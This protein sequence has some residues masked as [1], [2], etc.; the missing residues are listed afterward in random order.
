[1]IRK[2]HV[3]YK[4]GE[5]PKVTGHWIEAETE[6]DIKRIVLKY[7]IGNPMGQREIEG[8]FIKDQDFISFYAG[9][10]HILSFKNVCVWSERDRCCL[11]GTPIKVRYEELTRDDKE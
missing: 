2:V 5:Y 3:R 6:E 8:V 4:D 1:M 10:P 7:K 9:H 11:V